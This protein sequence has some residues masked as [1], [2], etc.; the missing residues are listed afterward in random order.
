MK[1]II[2]SGIK[3]V[4]YYEKKDT[5]YTGIADRNL[6]QAGVITVRYIYKYYV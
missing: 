3:K 2:Q 1:L 5:T 4:V 6:T